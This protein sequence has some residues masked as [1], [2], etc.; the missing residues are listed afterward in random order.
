MIVKIF[1]SRA[2]LTA[3]DSDTHEALN[4]CIKALWQKLKNML[5]K[6]GMA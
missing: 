5:V 3:S 4:P 6:Y 1:Y 2:R